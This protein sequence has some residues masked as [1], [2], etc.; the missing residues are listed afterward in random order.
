MRVPAVAAVVL[1]SRGGAP[2]GRALASV[3]WAGERMVLDPATRLV[4]EPLPRGVRLHAG[5][6]EPSELTTAPW[7]LLLAEEEIASPEVAAAIAA[8]VEAPRARSAY[9]IP[10]VV[11]GFGATL[12]PPRPPIRLAR[13]SQ[14]R[15]RIG[16]GLAVALGPPTGR[17]GRLAPPLIVRAA[18]RWSDAV[19]DL[20]A[21]ATTLAALLAEHRRRPRLWDLALGSLGAGARALIARPARQPASARWFLAVLAGYRAAVAYAKL[22]ERSRMEG[23]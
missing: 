22:W 4:R 9:R 12:T 15:L 10:V 19:D 8:V 1:A 2:L 6:A 18:E 3:A 5:T 11:E 17:A 7:V 16:R 21:Q 23:W 20:D 14:A 13:R